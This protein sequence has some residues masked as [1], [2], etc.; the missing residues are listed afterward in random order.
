[1]G[2]EECKNL[3]EVESILWRR[4]NGLLRNQYLIEGLQKNFK[5]F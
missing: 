1:M 4:G 2:K 5:G 3:S